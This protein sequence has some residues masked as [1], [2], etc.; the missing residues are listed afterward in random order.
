VEVLWLLP[1]V[2]VWAYDGYL[3]V[4]LLRLQRQIRRLRPM[5]FVPP[6]S[7]QLPTVCSSGGICCGDL[8]ASAG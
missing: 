1:T 3:L 8:G 7:T 5:M 4:R 2:A 6:M